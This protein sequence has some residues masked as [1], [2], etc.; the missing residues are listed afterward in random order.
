[1]GRRIWLTDQVAGQA[2]FCSG[3][4]TLPAWAG[5]SPA[6]SQ[7]AAWKSSMA[8]KVLL[9]AAGLAQ[10]G[11]EVVA[12]ALVGVAKAPDKA[13]GHLARQSRDGCAL[14]RTRPHLRTGPR[15]VRDDDGGLP[16]EPPAALAVDG[17]GR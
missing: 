7:R 2:G 3:R 6:T 16:D 15:S 12:L 14:K 8:M 17:E 1:M 13:A 11:E 4:T 9:G 5:T 10:A